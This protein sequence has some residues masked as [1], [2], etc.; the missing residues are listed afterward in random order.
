MGYACLV[1]RHAVNS[2]L[3]RLQ[4]VQSKC[5]LIISGTSWYVN[6]LQ[7]HED[8]E[9]AYTAEHI[10]ILTQSFDSKIPGVQSL[11][12]RQLGSIFPTQVMSY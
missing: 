5:L 12:V 6:S 3:R 7:L 8:L 1:W 11:Q 4:V 10:G 9:F 2:Q